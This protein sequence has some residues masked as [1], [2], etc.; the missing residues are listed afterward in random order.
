LALTLYSLVPGSLQAE[1]IGMHRFFGYLAL[2]AA[3]LGLWLLFAAPHR[4]DAITQQLDGAPGTYYGWA[5]GLIMGLTL[6][7]LAGIDWKELPTRV[8]GWVRLQ[9]RRVGLIVL[10]GLFA[11]ILLLF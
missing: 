6:A 2:G 4:T 5:A 7:W 9:R 1:G 8:G 11:G 10:G 3:G